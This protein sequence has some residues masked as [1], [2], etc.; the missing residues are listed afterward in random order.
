MLMQS[1]R[2]IVLLGLGPG[3]ANLMT[4]E[5]GE[6]PQ[7]IPGV[8]L[9]TRQHPAV[10]GFPTQLKVQSFDEVY[11][12]GESFEAVYAQIIERV[13]ELGRRPEGVTYAVPGHPFEA[14]TTGPEIARRAREEGIPVRVIE[15]ISFLDPV[16]TALGIDPFPA[17][18]LVDG[19]DLAVRHVPAFPPD[20]PALISQ[21]YSRQ[22]ASDVKLTLNAVY[23]DEHPVRLVHAAGTPQQLVEDLRLYEIDRSEHIGLLTALY[24]PPLA[25][26]GS[27][28][29]FQEIV[30]HLR[31][32]DGCPWDKEQTLQS[33]G[34]NLLEETHEALEALDEENFDGLREELGDLILLVTMLAQIAGEEGLF[35]MTDVIQGI[36]RK[37][38]RRHPHVFGDVN[39]DGTAGVLLNWERLKE[40]ERKQKNGQDAPV[41]AK[42]LLDGVSKSLPSLSQAQQY[43]VRAAHVGFDWPDIEGV[44]QKL[45]EEWAEVGAAHGSE[46]LENELGDLLFSA[47]NLVRWH[48]LDAETVLRKAN[49]RFYRRFKYIEAG[50]RKSGRNLTDLSL[51]ELEAL[52]QEAK[53]EQ[54]P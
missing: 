14:E 3:D 22:V 13:L 44:K 20:S 46:Q 9:R 42:G 1:M 6:S 38:V 15:G 18:A 2:G 39:V 12:A 47:V 34:P 8:W 21:I 16:C 54:H 25:R 29:G 4:R 5:A 19:L 49:Q 48:K 10:E 35:Q 27:L 11:E 28:E 50:A 33:L 30:A 40:D 43:Q 23:P 32:P 26:D 37:I 24:V 41:E 51:D 52:W 36:H 53:K 7:Q 17:L 31:A 45:L